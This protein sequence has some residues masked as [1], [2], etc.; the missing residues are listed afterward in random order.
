MLCWE[1]T[2]GLGSGLR[3]SWMLGD[4]PRVRGHRHGAGLLVSEGLSGWKEQ[5]RPGP[6]GGVGPSHKSRAA[7]KAASD[8]PVGSRGP[9]EGGGSLRHRGRSRAP[10]L[11]R[12]VSFKGYLGG[13]RAVRHTLRNRGVNSGFVL[14]LLCAHVLS[15]S[16]RLSKQPS[17]KR[18]RSFCF[19]GGPMEAVRDPAAAGWVS[20]Q[21]M[22]P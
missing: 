4:A 14:C 8:C 22:A 3:R 18:L 7:P 9:G 12:V 20:P 16:P 13:Q 1:P 17:E 21:D 15:T 5:M 6:W 2:P 10:Q 19:S 11:Y